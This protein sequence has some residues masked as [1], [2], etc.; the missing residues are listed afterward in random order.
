MLSRSPVAATLPFRGLQAALDFYSNKLELTLVSGSV[1]EG[2]LEF[3]AG[4]G[5]AL[6]VFESD[7]RK[8]DDT[9]A[10]FRVRDLAKE[11]EDL[12]ERGV[13]FE[14]YDLPGIQTVDGVATM[15][16]EKAAWFKDPGGNILCLHQGG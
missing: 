8:S 15:G 7:S 4:D 6:G 11:M 5:T 10:T 2:H 3:E 1:Q 9:G 14:E 13:T 12:R 16:N